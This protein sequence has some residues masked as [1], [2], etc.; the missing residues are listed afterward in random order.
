MEL[1]TQSMAVAGIMPIK[2]QS[3]YEGIKENGGLQG[4][5]SGLIL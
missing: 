4:P 1:L 3:D 5:P 2:F